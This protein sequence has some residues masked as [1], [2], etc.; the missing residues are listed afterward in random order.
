MSREGGVFFGFA[1]AEGAGFRG[2]EGG[3]GDWVPR[4]FDEVEGWVGLVEPR[5]FIALSR[6]RWSR[7]VD[8]VGEADR[9]GGSDPEESEADGEDAS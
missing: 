1:D 2:P 7:E 3:A 6:S 9:E 5:G 4:A 8:K